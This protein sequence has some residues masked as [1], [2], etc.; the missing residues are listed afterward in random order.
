MF[1]TVAEF[2]RESNAGT[3]AQALNLTPQHVLMLQYLMRH[4]MARISGLACLVGNVHTSMNRLRAALKPLG[5]SV[6]SRRGIGFTLTCESKM[7]VLELMQAAIKE[8]A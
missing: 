6:V 7:K 5:V 3:I 4:D 8:V 1:E 2:A